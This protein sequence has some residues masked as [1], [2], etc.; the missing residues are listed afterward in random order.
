LARES[1]GLDAEH[2]RLILSYDALLDP[3]AIWSLGNDPFAWTPLT[4]EEIA[5]R[6]TRFVKQL[7]SRA[8]SGPYDWH[9][10]TMLRRPS[11]AVER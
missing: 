8:E 3:L 6:E 1:R 9:A 5:A 10:D 11:R 7:Q 2:F 4:A